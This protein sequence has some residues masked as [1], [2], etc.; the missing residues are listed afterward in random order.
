MRKGK[1]SR[2]AE[3]V[4]AWRGLAGLGHESYAPDPVAKHLVSRPVRALLRAAEKSPGIAHFANGV[5][6]KLSGGV[7]RHLPLRT[8]AIDDA[9][10]IEI[11]RGVTQ[12]VLLGAGLDG[13]AHRLEVLS[14]CDLFEIDHPDTQ[15]LKLQNARDLPAYPRQIHY[16]PVNLERD[17]FGEAL[18]ANG[19]D[20][21]MPAV[22]IWEGVTMYLP[23]AAIEGTLALL[24]R[25]ACPG[26]LVMATYFD[27]AAERRTRFALP[28]FLAIGEALRSSFSKTEIA[29]L[30]AKHGFVIDADEGDPEWGDRYVGKRPLFVMSERLVLARRADIVAPPVSQ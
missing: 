1:S 3:F 13:R 14:K 29:A 20:P 16:V 17:D 5:L 21:R 10:K 19:F 25:F 4:S 7:W 26:S 2:T 8:R 11:R 12:V 6:T 23:L 9:L 15:A 18:V 27:K 24:N 22:F 28:L 30:F